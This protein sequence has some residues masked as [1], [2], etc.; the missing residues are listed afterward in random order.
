MPDT[1][2]MMRR[3]VVMLGLCAAIVACG[4]GGSEPVETARP[5]LFA[6]EWRS[7]TPTL[8]F[9]RLTLQPK[10]SERD[11]IAAR[12][13]FSG[14]YWDGSGRIAGDSLVLE[15]SVLGQGA[16]VR[17]LVARVGGDG[18]L[19]AVARSDVA[20]PFSVDFVREN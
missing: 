12:L 20:A 10:S 3:L 4:D 16:D 11:A 6:G 8:E 5:E 2:E 13:T 7:V 18:T 15:M 14:V 17:T 9:L 19:H 1:R